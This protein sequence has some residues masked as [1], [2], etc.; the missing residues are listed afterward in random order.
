MSDPIIATNLDTPL[1]L[2]ARNGDTEALEAL[3]SSG[4][5]VDDVDQNGRTA[6]IHAAISGEFDTAKLLLNAGANVN[7]RDSE[8]RTAAHYTILGRSSVRS[9]RFLKRLLVKNN[10][11]FTIRDNLSFTPLMLCA[12]SGYFQ[13]ISEG[14]PDLAEILID[15]GVD[16]NF[17]NIKGLTALNI[18][19]ADGNVAVCE[20]L[21]KAGAGPKNPDD[22]DWQSTIDAAKEAFQPIFKSMLT[23]R[24]LNK[25]SSVA[26]K[27]FSSTKDEKL[28]FN[29]RKTRL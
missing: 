26:V 13:L 12:K 29:N 25:V 11:D 22:D 18:A 2:A 16:V 28:V 21:I 6:F 8:G 24:A 14:R 19:A 27:N 23:Q 5:N 3:L 7:A 1:M 15:A 4:V 17:R 9:R 10:A 20:L